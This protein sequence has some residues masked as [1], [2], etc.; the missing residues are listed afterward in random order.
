MCPERIRDHALG[1]NEG[2]AIV[3]H[4]PVRH[5]Q[6][7]QGLQP[8]ELAEDQGAVRPR[9]GER[10]IEVVAAGLGREATADLD[11]SAEHRLWTGKSAA[12]LR[13]SVLFAAPGR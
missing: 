2:P 12:R 7:D 8:L 5:G 4:Q 3:T 6:P 11:V 9:T 13:C 10:G 1:W